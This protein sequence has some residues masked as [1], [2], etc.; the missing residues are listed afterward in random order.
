[1]A[2]V[3]IWLSSVQSLSRVQWCFNFLSWGFLFRL[4]LIET[5]LSFPLEVTTV[6]YACQKQCFSGW[7][8]L[9]IPSSWL[10]PDTDSDYVWDE[11]IISCHW[12]NHKHANTTLRKTSLHFFRR[13]KNCYNDTSALCVNSTLA[14]HLL[15]WLLGLMQGLRQE[16]KRL[17]RSMI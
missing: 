3:I 16:L 9:M 1:M 7:C 13:I 17:E 14:F 8:L 6:V 10:M 2:A 11:T 12:Q 15:F 4:R 5:T